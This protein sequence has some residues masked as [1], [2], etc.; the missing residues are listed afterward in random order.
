M[1]D[2][3]FFSEANTR[4]ARKLNPQEKRWKTKALVLCGIFLLL[5]IGQLLFYHIIWNLNDW[6]CVLI[7]QI[8]LIMPAYL[9]N[10]GMLL[11]GKGGKPLD[12]EIIC[13]D[14]NRLFGP[15]KT[16]RGFILGPIFGI[17]IALIIHSIFFFTWEGIE[18]TIIAFFGGQREYVLFDIPPDVAVNIF[19][20]YM[21]GARLH[22]TLWFGLLRLIPRIV[23]ISYG[24]AVGDL[25]GSWLKRRLNKNRG[26]P[27][28]GVDQLDFIA[29]AILLSIPFVILNWTFLTVLVFIAIFTPSM[30]LIANIVAY[31]VGIKNIPY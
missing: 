5:F 18:N 31:L 6:T 20:V 26:E 19:K 8:V 9:S 29:P 22:E 11:F 30:A 21:T 28:W 27:L 3:E 15:G 14:G 13:E 1:K 16:I 17:L 12:K 4:N 23:L 25:I 2:N 10:A 7:L 24:A